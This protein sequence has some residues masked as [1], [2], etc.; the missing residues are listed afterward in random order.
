MSG[1]SPGNYTQEKKN[2]W[3]Q[4]KKFKWT[5]GGPWPK[6]PVDRPGKSF[7]MRPGDH[8]AWGRSSSGQ[9]GDCP[10]WRRSFGGRPRDFLSLGMSSGRWTGDKP[11]LRKSSGGQPG[12]H[13]SPGQSSAG[14]QDTTH[15]RGGALWQTWRPWRL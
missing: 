12:D 14:G 15:S 7:D 5:T 1:T 8:L 4:P 13:P 3:G 11:F 9:P 6:P 10:L 2:T